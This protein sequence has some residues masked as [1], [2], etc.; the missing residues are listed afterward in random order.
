M[1]IEIR[2]LNIRSTIASPCGSC[3]FDESGEQGAA[4]SDSGSETLD[5]CRSA[6]HDT[7]RQA[8]ER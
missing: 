2:Q 8:R 7:L 5:L 6:I 4:P 3:S 1:P